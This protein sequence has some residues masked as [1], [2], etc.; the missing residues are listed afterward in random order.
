L[1]AL[2][3]QYF[4]DDIR[5]HVPGHGPVAG[6]YEGTPQVLQL[7]VRLCELSGGTF[8]IDLHDVVANDEHAVALFTVRGEREGKQLND[9]TA[10]SYHIRDGK[11]SEAW[12]LS[13]RA[14]WGAASR[15]TIATGWPQWGQSRRVGGGGG[16]GRLNFPPIAGHPRFGVNGCDLMG[17]GVV[18]SQL[19]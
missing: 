4:T 15:V 3:N 8:R 17:C 10:Q 11:I 9:N 14:T 2:Q 12:T 16:V 13:T 1:D 19:D 18:R 6:D 7:F 5:W